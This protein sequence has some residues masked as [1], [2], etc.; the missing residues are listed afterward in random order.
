MLIKLFLRIIFGY[1]R[2]EVEGY[3]IERFI[4]IC[5]NRKILIWNLKRK[6]EVQILLN[7]GINDFK[8]ISDI[9]KRT[10]CKVRIKAKKGIP[11]LLYKYKKRK[12]FALFFIIILITIFISSRYIWNIEV[13][14]QDNQIIENIEEEL[15]NCGLKPG[16]KKNSIDT[17]RIINELRLKRSDVA[18]VRNRY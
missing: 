16:I 9:V 1:V 3:Y 11:F 6:N 2:I 15:E 14:V 17:Y 7:I 13:L 5:T 8:K 12:I 10:N 18:W 4:N